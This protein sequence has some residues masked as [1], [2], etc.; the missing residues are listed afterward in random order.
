MGPDLLLGGVA[1]LVLVAVIIAALTANKRGEAPGKGKHSAAE[2][3]KR[4]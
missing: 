3:S 2:V 1:G 4:R